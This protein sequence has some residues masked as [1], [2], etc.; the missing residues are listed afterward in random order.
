MKKDFENQLFTSMNFKRAH[1]NVIVSCT[2]VVSV[3]L[4]LFGALME[5]VTKNNVEQLSQYNNYHFSWMSG[6]CLEV[7][8]VSLNLSMKILLGFEHLKPLKA[9]LLAR[10]QIP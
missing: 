8:G 5:Q 6:N 9:V 1:A 2:H 7:P 10:S 3:L 4:R